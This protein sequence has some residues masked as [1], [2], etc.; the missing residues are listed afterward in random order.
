M[1]LIG[2][3]RGAHLV[4][5]CIH[6]R[7]D[8]DI[9]AGAMDHRGAAARQ[10]RSVSAMFASDTSHIATEQPSAAKASASSRPIPVP[11]PVMT[12][13]FPAK[14]FSAIILAPELPGLFRLSIFLRLPITLKM[15]FPKRFG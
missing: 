7:F 13:I 10:S 4:G 14:S 8:R 2:I 9:G 3:K 6:L 11:P 15:P 1:D 12:A 5:P